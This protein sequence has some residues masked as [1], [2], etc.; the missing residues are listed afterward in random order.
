MQTAPLFSWSFLKHYLTT[1]RPYL[2]FVSGIT[3]LT[4][5]SFVPDLA[6]WRTLI[7]FAVFFLSYGFGQALTDC[8]QIDTDTLSSP[9]RPLTRGAIRK[10]DVLLVSLSGLG[11]SGLILARA[12]WIN[13]P[14]SLLAVFGLATYTYFK[15]RWWAGPFYNAWIVLLLC[16]IAFTAGMGQWT[17]YRVL[18]INFVLTAVMVFF[19]YAN[20]VLVGYF[21]D[22]SADCQTGYRTFPVVYGFKK[23]SL[24]SDAFALL[25]ISAWIIFVDLNRTTFRWF[26]G[27]FGVSGLL[28]L[29]YTQIMAYRLRSEKDAHQAV[30]PVVHAYILILGSI[31]ISQKPAWTLWIFVFYA[32]FV[33]TLK[34]RPEQNQI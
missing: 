8:F 22:V 26:A 11:V 1:M 29:L 3:G 24:L 19:G 33:L 27:L 2:M 4:G 18:S 16:I 34:F 10:K 28:V 17:G 30:V 20:F 32:A 14:L 23:S 6:P 13:L 5:L 7:L 25:T 9:Y 21:K 15:K 12:A 31:V